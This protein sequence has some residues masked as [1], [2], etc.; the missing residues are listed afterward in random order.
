MG[1][2][3]VA[4]LMNFACFLET[5][6]SPALQAVAAHWHEARGTAPMPSWEQLNPSR[7][8]PHLSILW[9]YRYDRAVGQFVGRLAG[10]AVAWGFEKNF[11]GLALQEAWPA[12]VAERS[13]LSMTRVISEPAVYRNAG[14]LFKQAGRTVEGERIILPL[15]G[16]GVHGDGVLGASAYRYALRTLSQG[17]VELIGDAEEWFALS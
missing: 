7:M 10:S 9:S 4:A 14:G 11:R 12:V 13:R 5:I 17:P 16:D 2:K 15:A 1:E 8:A 3:N 6:S